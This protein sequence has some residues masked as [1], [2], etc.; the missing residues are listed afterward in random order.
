M[1]LKTTW[2]CDYTGYVIFMVIMKTTTT[3][4][5]VWTEMKTMTTKRSPIWREMV[6]P[7]R[8]PVWTRMTTTTRTP[9][10]SEM[11]PAVSASNEKDGWEFETEYWT[12]WMDEV[13]T[14]PTT[15]S[16]STLSPVWK[17]MSSKTTR[18]PM[19]REMVI[20]TTNPKMDEC[21][22]E[23]QYIY[24]GKVCGIDGKTYTNACLIHCIG[25]VS[26]I[27]PSITILLIM[28]LFSKS[29]FDQTLFTNFQ[30]VDCHHNCPC[31]LISSSSNLI[32]HL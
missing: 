28:C 23:C 8:T 5:P 27:L 9:V 7:T 25:V 31:N 21:A 22:D 1:I 4:T 6:I 17:E 12:E 11:A 14:T 15:A 19:W 2:V 30:E 32:E 18:S 10:W 29:N 20:P 3:R 13:W 26:Y 24:G 16:T